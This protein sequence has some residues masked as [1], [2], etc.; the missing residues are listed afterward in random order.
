MKR[1]FKSKY[2]IAVLLLV[3]CSAT[4]AY[5]QTRRGWDGHMF[6]IQNNPQIRF[7]GQLKFQSTK[8]SASTVMTVSTGGVTLGTEANLPLTKIQTYRVSLTPSS[9]SNHQTNFINVF[10]TQS[11]AVTGLAVS[12]V[13]FIN[14]PGTSGG[15]GVVGAKIPA[16]DTLVVNVL[17]ATTGACTP[18]AGIYQI[19]AIRT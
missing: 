10:T 15:C 2:G 13:V 18:A 19:V 11:L 4:Y 17:H 12:D 5:A 9:W 1:F 6:F 7:D 14:G 3:I 8:S 16:A